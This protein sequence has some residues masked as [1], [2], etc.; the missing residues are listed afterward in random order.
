MITATPA[1]AMVRFKYEYVLASARETTK[2]SS[3]MGAQVGVA[4]L[5]PPALSANWSSTRALMVRRKRSSISAH[6][7]NKR[8]S[9]APCD[10][11]PSHRT[12]QVKHR[13]YTRH[14]LAFSTTGQFA[15]QYL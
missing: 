15:A 8:G 7:A 11:M 12:S 4:W 5:A 6:S 9:I 10:P 1:V 13:I 14:P 2:I 3:D